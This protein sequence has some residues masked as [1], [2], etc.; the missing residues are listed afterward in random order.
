MRSLVSQEEESELPFAAVRTLPA[1]TT[2]LVT[3]RLL[4]LRE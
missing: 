4:G 3:G 2:V 1:A